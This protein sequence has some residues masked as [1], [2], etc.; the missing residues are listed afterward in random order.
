M[1]TGKGLFS[2][3]DRPLSAFFK[4]TAHEDRRC[5]AGKKVDKNTI[6]IPRRIFRRHYCAICSNYANQPR[7]SALTREMAYLAQRKKKKKKECYLTSIRIERPSLEFNCELCDA[8]FGAHIAREY[9]A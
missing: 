5:R 7:L 2:R 1:S 6:K 4:T 8:L 3:H 9:P